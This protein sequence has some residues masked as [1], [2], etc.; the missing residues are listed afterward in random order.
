MAVLGPTLAALG[1][2][3]GGFEA[4]L[5]VLG[6]FL[7]ASKFMNVTRSSSMLR[8]VLRFHFCRFPTVIQVPELW[9][10]LPEA[11]GINFHQ[12]ASQS[13]LV[14]PSYDQN[15]QMAKKKIRQNLQRWLNVFVFIH[16]MHL[17]GAHKLRN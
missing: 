12:V 10:K 9:N 11:P 8:Q 3:L 5:A 1:A 2:A 13:E 7:R 14:G 6:P 16:I 17:G 15:T 4:V